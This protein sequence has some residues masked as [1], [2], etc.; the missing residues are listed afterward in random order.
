MAEIKFPYVQI[1]IP[2]STPYP[3]GQ[4]V[5]RPMA[6]ASLTASNGESLRCFVCVDTGADACIFPLQFA[7]ALKIDVLTLPSTLTGGVGSNSNVTYYDTIQ[8]DLG[9]GISFSA[10][11]GFT[12]AL[13]IQ[14]IGL[15]GQDGFFSAYDVHFS[16]RQAIFT[17]TT[18]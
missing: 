2:A 10:Y 7:I 3:Q 4:N 16:H 15:L 6:I 8:I 18:S 9:Q 1:Q 5:R 14:G 13:N 17:V 11:V 12:E